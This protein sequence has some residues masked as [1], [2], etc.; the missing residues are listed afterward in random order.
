[1]VSTKTR[2]IQRLLLRV[3]GQEEIGRRIKQAREDADLTQQQLAAAIGVQHPQS[4]SRYERGE[5]E[6]PA[7]RLRRIAEATS[8]SMSFFIHEPDEPSQNGTTPDPAT[9]G[10]FE[11]AVD[12]FVLGVERLE[13]VADRLETQ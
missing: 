7:K 6:V 11:A 13:A 10:R 8:K 5:T 3:I 1:M 12:A 2:Q 4:I 9:L